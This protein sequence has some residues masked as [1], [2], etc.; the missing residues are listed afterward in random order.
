MEVRESEDRGCGQTS[1]HGSHCPGCFDSDL[2]QSHFLVL[3][4]VAHK[5]NIA[6][7]SV[8]QRNN[9]WDKKL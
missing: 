1:S 8:K 6:V 5:E 7:L 2:I 3:S 9:D 4:S